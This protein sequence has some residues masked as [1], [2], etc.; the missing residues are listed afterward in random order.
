MANRLNI[1][2]AAH[3]KRHGTWDADRRLADALRRRA[4]FLEKHPQHRAMQGEIDRILEKA[5]SAENR[6]AVL[7]LL[8]EAKLIELH[9]ALQR[10]NR[11]VRSVAA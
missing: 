7:A 8:M 6:M 2:I 5:G 11:V 4:R 3:R 1:D 9:G 10:L